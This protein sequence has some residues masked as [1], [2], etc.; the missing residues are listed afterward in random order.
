[1]IIITTAKKIRTDLPDGRTVYSKADDFLNQTVMPYT[2]Y[3]IRMVLRII[4]SVWYYQTVII[5]GFSD[6][7]T[8]WNFGRF[9]RTSWWDE[10]T[11]RIINTNKWFPVNKDI[12]FRIIRILKTISS[13]TFAI[14]SFFFNEKILKHL[15]FELS[16]FAWQ[17]VHLTMRFMPLSEFATNCSNK[18]FKQINFTIT[19]LNSESEAPQT[20]DSMYFIPIFEFVMNCLNKVF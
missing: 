9:Y 10:K 19:I 14:F 11:K 7:F 6:A 13:K 1:M 17:S 18:W 4:S 2:D 8:G 12:I 15:E 3:I 20:M 5:Y 16:S